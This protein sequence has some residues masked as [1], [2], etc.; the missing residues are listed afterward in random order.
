MRPIRPV[1]AA[2]VTCASILHAAVGPADQDPAGAGADD[3]RLGCQV[4]PTAQEIRLDLDPRRS[5]YAGSVR[6]DLRVVQPVETIRM[7]AQEMRLARIVLEGPAGEVPVSSESGPGGLV[8]LTSAGTLAP[9]AYTL[10]ID[11]TNDLNTKAIGLYRVEHEGSWYSFT[12]L[13]A[14]DAREAFPCWDEPS[15]KI[16]YRMIL[17]IPEADTAVT[18]TPVERE[19][20]EGGTRTLVFARTRPLPAYLLAIASGPLETTP[21]EGMGVPGRVITVKGRSRLAGAAAEETPRLLRAAERYFGSSYPFEKLDLIAIPEFW[22]GAME[23]PGAVTFADTLLL[24]DPE[25]ASL[26]QRRSLAAVTAHEL[27]HMWFGDLVTMRWWDDL[28]LNE[29][30]ADWLGTKLTHE[31][32]PEYGIDLSELRSTQAVMKSD[33]RPS[34]QA[35][36]RTVKASDN[37]LENVGTAYAKGSAVLGMF[38]RWMGPETFRK[39]ILEYLRAH[40]WGNAEA[41]DLW[42]ALGAAAGADVTTAMATFL[43]QPGLPLVRAEALPGGGVRLSQRRFLPQGMTAPPQRWRIPVAL[44]YPEGSATRIRTV[45]LQ[46]DRQVVDLGGPPAWVLPD[47]EAAGYYRWSV[48]AD[49]LA[50][51]AREAPRRL[52]PRERIGFIGNLEALLSAGEVGG[53]AYLRA[54]G[55]FASDAHPVVV[56]SLAGTLTSIRVPLVPEGGPQERYAR[57]LRRTL[58]PALERLGTAP[59]AG[60]DESAT[61]VRP[62]LM[63]LLGV[64]GQDEALLAH[65]QERARAYLRDPASV[66][67]SLVEVILQ[68]AAARGGRDLFEDFRRRAEAAQVPADRVRFLSALGYFRDPDLVEEALR[69]SAS[70]LLRARE[71]FQVTGGL[72]LTAAGRDRLFKHVTDNYDTLAARLPEEAMGFLPRFAGGCEPERVEAARRFFGEPS[73]DKRGTR[74]TLEK[75]ADQVAECVSLRSR[76][77]AAVAAFLAREDGPA[78]GATAAPRLR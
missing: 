70:G 62:Q 28:W 61:L 15:F 13:E 3:L 37:L 73:R 69:Y 52:D 22:P 38:E 14:D 72:V 71:L 17:R 76:E 26:D 33:A 20:A 18:N 30:F 49:Q 56:A 59:G 60:E 27:A 45:L 8:T 1:L 23:N 21:I 24:L 11:F 32:H 25:S 31:L 5:D 36:H 44:K 40:A 67:A 2:L 64:V 42:S 78:P 77:A 48:P 12:Q 43:A 74:T 57:Y 29:S 51:M 65:A 58:G 41:A 9:G 47:A 10:A 63:F 7:H 53:D 35:I 4:L 68:L 55:S 50:A 34:A 75:V 6:I 16:P 54:L 46:D 66:D 19:T 39:G